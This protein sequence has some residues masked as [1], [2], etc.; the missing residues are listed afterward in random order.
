MSDLTTTSPLG[1]H[2]LLWKSQYMFAKMILTLQQ[3]SG[4]PKSKSKATSF[5]RRSIMKVRVHSLRL[6][7]RKMRTKWH[8][9]MDIGSKCK[10]RLRQKV[11]E[12]PIRVFNLKIFR[13]ASRLYHSKRWRHLRLKRRRKRNNKTQR[14]HQSGHQCWELSLWKRKKHFQVIWQVL[15]NKSRRRGA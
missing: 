4:Q 15:M 14:C 7:L 5:K 9:V 13:S 11:V 3:T 12:C 8:R 6:S 10:H 2:S 1:I